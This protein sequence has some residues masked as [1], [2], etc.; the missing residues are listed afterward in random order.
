MN[1]DKEEIINYD[2]Q[3]WP[4]YKMNLREIIQALG[5]VYNK[6]TCKWEIKESNNLDVYP[7]R[8]IDDGMGYGVDEQYIV[9]VSV[10]DGSNNTPRCNIFTEP[11]L[12]NKDIWDEV[13]VFPCYTFE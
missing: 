13:G 12:E 9:E 5:G 8:L 11:I 4:I 6:H 10:F 3:G 2:S 1:R 7:T